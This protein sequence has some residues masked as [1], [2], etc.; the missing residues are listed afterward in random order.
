MLIQMKK[1]PFPMYGSVLGASGAAALSSENPQTI[2][3]H[4]TFFFLTY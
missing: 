4:F 2:F 1:A 3:L